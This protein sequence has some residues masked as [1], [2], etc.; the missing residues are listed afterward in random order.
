MGENI[1][2]DFLLIGL[3]KCMQELW[4]LHEIKERIAQEMQ[5][6]AGTNILIWIHD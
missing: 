1:K 4:N 2:A 5:I 3:Q 6:N